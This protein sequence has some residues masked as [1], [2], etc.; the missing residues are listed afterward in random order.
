MKSPV[1]KQ[2][3]SEEVTALVQVRHGGGWDQRVTQVVRSGQI[4]NLF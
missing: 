1:R 3:A 2:E 4:L